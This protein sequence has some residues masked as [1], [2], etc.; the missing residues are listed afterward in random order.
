[1]KKKELTP[2]QLAVCA[3]RKRDKVSAIRWVHVQRPEWSLLQAKEFFETAE[4]QRV[5]QKFNQIDDLM[6]S[7]ISNA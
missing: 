3:L 1:M 5:R 6:M 4:F 7:E 2:N